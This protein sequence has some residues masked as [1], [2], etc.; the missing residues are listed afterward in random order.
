M[1]D[2]DAA[3]FQRAAGKNQVHVHQPGQLL[4]QMFQAVNRNHPAGTRPKL[5][6]SLPASQEQFDQDGQLRF[7]EG[8]PFAHVVAVPFRPPGLGVDLRHQSQ[9]A[10][11][12]EDLRGMVF[13]VVHNRMPIALLIACRRNGL[14]RQRIVFGRRER[15]LDQHAQDS[16][17]RCRQLLDPRNL[18]FVN[19]IHLALAEFPGNESEALRNPPAHTSSVRSVRDRERRRCYIIP[20]S[21]AIPPRRARNSNAGR[22]R[23]PADG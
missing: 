11:F 13:A 14:Q 3:T 21:D 23:R 6:L 9:L 20:K 17:L 19:L 12:V 1:V 22:L 10:Q 5:A 15:L 2:F 4:P 8:E 7:G 18:S 16:S